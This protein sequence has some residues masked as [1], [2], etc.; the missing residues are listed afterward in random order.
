MF[1]PK[2]TRRIAEFDWKN[3]RKFSAVFCFL[4]FMNLKDI[5]TILLKV[6]N[7][8]RANPYKIFNFE[9]TSDL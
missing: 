5:L 4:T 3:Y 7:L 8:K 1:F 9:K 2:P 6:D